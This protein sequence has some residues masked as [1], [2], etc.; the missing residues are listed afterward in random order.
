MRDE[1]I[2]GLIIALVIVLVVLAIYIGFIVLG[3]KLAIRKNRSPHWMWFAIHPVGLLVTLIVMACLSPL[4]RCPQC[5]Q[6]TPEH[7][8]L[9]GFCGYNYAMPA[10]YAPPTQPNIY[11]PPPQW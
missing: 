4:K 9:C 8:R 7:A 3:V 10:A 6:T 2:F 11:I 1:E 5:R